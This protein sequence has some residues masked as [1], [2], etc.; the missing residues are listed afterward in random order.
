MN[1]SFITAIFALCL[2]LQASLRAAQPLAA[3][4]QVVVAE[5]ALPVTRFA[6]EEL[7]QHAGRISGKPVEV[8]TPSTYRQRKENLSFFVGSGAAQEALDLQLSPWKTDEEWMLKT[9]PQGLLLAGNDAP[10]S[11]TSLRVAA[12]SQLAVYTLLDDYLGAKWFW[13]G[14]SGEHLPSRPDAVIPTLDRRESPTFIIRQYGVGYGAYHT[15]SFRKE[16]GKWQ[17]RTRQGWVPRAWFGH[18]WAYA[19]KT[20]EDGG[21]LLEKHP[22]WFALVEGKRRRP[23]MC[24]THPEVIDRM[25]AFVLADTKNA[26]TSIS[27]NDGKGFCECERCRALDDPERLSYDGQTPELSDRI[28]TYA[29]EVARRVREKDPAKG[30][31]IFAYTYYTT[32]PVRIKKLEPNLYLSF[33]HTSRDDLDPGH[34]AKWE[35][36]ISQWQERGARMILREGWGDHYL[37][38]LPFLYPKQIHHAV[39]IAVRNGFVANYGEGS[40]AF[41]TQLPNTWVAVRMMWNPGQSLER[42]TDQLYASAYGPVAD[43]MKAFFRTYENALKKNWPRRRMILPRPDVNYENLY[44]SWT[45]LFPREVVET[46]QAH[47]RQAEAKAPPGEYADRVAFHRI[48]QEYTRTMLELFGTYQALTDLG[49]TGLGFNPSPEASATGWS[50]SGEESRQA[51]LQRAYALG[52]KREAL[53]L[54]HRDRAALDEGLYAFTNDKGYRQWHAAIK[55]ALGITTPSRLT[56]ESLALEPTP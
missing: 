46:A 45:R 34:A 24:T 4:Q 50:D 52:E 16:V 40:K 51:L 41:S 43:E 54:A 33:V 39:R 15:P 37:L 28:F 30:V 47:L 42:L 26:I 20:E 7:A 29:N 6:A 27:P 12:G 11:A 13:P 38:D 19:F 56:G 25:V 8:I 55:K 32:P 48:G 1:R 3:F 36:L 2:A 5:D 23:Q 18:S 14:P 53:L 22:D 17:R 31:G 49:M 35:K 9:I 21:D 10:G 44:N